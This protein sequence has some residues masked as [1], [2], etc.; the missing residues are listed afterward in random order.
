MAQLNLVETLTWRGT[1][2]WTLCYAPAADAPACAYLI[3]NP[4]RPTLSIPVHEGV[5][6]GMSLRKLP[7]GIREGL[8]HAPSVEGVHWPTWD[9]STKSGVD[10]VIVLVR[11]LSVPQPASSV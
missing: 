3:A 2:C 7:K 9:M 6:A 10:E 5:L 4:Q 8:S 1:W 11:M